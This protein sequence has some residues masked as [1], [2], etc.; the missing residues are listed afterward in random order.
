MRTCVAL[1]ALCVLL[2]P[3]THIA[4]A[5]WPNVH[6]WLCAAVTFFASFAIFYWLRRARGCGSTTAVLYV[7]SALAISEV[8]IYVCSLIGTYGFYVAAALS[9]LQF[10]C[11]LSARKNKLANDIESFTPNDDFFGF[12]TT[13]LSSKRFLTATATSIGVLSIVD[14]FL[15]GY[16]DGTPIAFQPATRVAYGLL[17]IAICVIVISLMMHKRKSVMTVGMFILLELFACAALVL[18]AA[19]PDMP[20]I[21]AVFTTTL[22]ALLVAFTWYIIIAFMSFGWRDP[23]Y[24]ALGGWI[25]WLGCRAIARVTLINVQSLSTNDLL[26]NAIMGT[27]VVISTQVALGQFLKVSQMEADERHDLHVR[28]MERLEKQLSRA[29][30]NVEALTILK[31]NAGE[32]SECAACANA[33]PMGAGAAGAVGTPNPLQ[34]AGVMPIESV[35]QGETADKSRNA[36]PG[37]KRGMRLVR[38]MGLDEGDSI[39]DIRKATMRNNAEQMG[40]QFLLSDR[41]IEVLALYALGWTQKRVAEELY[42]SPSTA[43]AHIKRIYAK[44]GLHS[45]QEILDFMDQYTS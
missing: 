43:H 16:P 45:R 28:R 41:E 21:G 5:F 35:D 36:Q 19:F 18:Y 1:E 17:T 8:E 25:V 33:A 3:L 29:Q 10:P 27:C 4:G 32:Y 40:K 22:N 14:G 44:T 7:F 6:F 20:D 30:A 2:L 34:C 31:N 9:L 24:Y 12:A 42:I 39:A 15:R 23:Y 13:L 38:L 37:S 11:M 26:I